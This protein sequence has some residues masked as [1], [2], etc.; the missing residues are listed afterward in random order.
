[1]IARPKTARTAAR[2][3]SKHPFE[4]TTPRHGAPIAGAPEEGPNAPPSD[5]PPSDAPPAADGADEG[6]APPAADAAADEGAAPDAA[7]DAAPDAEAKRA[8]PARDAFAGVL[9]NEGNV[10]AIL[11]FSGYRSVLALERQPPGRQMRTSAAATR[12]GRRG[13]DVRTAGHARAGFGDVRTGDARA[14]A[15]NWLWPA[16]TGYALT[17]LARDAATCFSNSHFIAATTFERFV[18]YQNDASRQRP[19]IWSVAPRSSK[20]HEPARWGGDE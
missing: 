19:R 6:A 5:A 10:T 8:R 17:S 14:G 12:R 13:P 1:M 2:P 20:I 9:E 15:F 18:V 3:E 16:V 4:S 7:A 11:G